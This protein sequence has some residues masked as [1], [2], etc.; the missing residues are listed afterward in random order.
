[1]L[2]RFILFSEG[3]FRSTKAS[4]LQRF[5]LCS[6]QF[7]N[8]TKAISCKL[9]PR[10]GSFWSSPLEPP[11]SY[12]DPLK[13][14]G[15]SSA[16]GLDLLVNKEASSVSEMEGAGGVPAS[17]SSTSASSLSIISPWSLYIMLLCLISNISASSSSSISPSSSRTSDRSSHKGSVLI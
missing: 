7:R 15:E 4:I 10:T 17:S 12:K 14:R 16:Y 6:G 5:K 13:L 1:M 8:R 11:G 9:L 3:N 2:L